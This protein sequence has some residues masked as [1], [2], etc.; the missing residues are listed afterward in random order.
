MQLLHYFRTLIKPEGAKNYYKA[1]IYKCVDNR[2]IEHRNVA[3]STSR[4]RG[5]DPLSRLRK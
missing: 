2:A 4:P 3:Y 1:Y 5:K